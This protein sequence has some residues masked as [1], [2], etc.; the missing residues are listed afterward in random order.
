MSQAKVKS[1]LVT[2]LVAIVA[3]A[4]ANRIGYTKKLING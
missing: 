3:V 2:G 4:V 1:Y